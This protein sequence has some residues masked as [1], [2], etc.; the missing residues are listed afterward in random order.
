MSDLKREVC[1]TDMTGRYVIGRG[2]CGQPKG[3]IG[4]CDDTLGR[5]DAAEQVCAVPAEPEQADLLD[6]MIRASHLPGLSA[7]YDELRDTARRLANLALA[8]AP[9]SLPAVGLARSILEMPAYPHIHSL[10]QTGNAPPSPWHRVPQ[11]PLVE[12]QECDLPDSDT[13]VLISPAPFD[14]LNSDDYRLAQLEF[15][16]DSEGHGKPYWS[17]PHGVEHSFEDY[18]FWTLPAPP[19]KDPTNG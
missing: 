3:H 2:C 12:G 18:P 4:P 14:E 11:L 17:E 8:Q 10:Q 1:G 6:A 13:T 16:D 7:A 9:D 15:T 5:D 19:T